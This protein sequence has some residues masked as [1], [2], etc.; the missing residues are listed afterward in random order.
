MLTLAFIGS[1]IALTVD[2]FALSLHPEGKL[3]AIAPSALAAFAITS[4]WMPA[5]NSRMRLPD[6][7][8]FMGEVVKL[9]LVDAAATP[10]TSTSPGS[11]TGPLPP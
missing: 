1:L 6:T 8:T 5:Y 3:I 2:G 11:T 7:V 10:P 4:W 9:R